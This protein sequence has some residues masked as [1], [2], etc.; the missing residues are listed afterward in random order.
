MLLPSL[1]YA[2]L[3]GFPANNSYT[4]EKI[5]FPV[6]QKQVSHKQNEEHDCRYQEL[7]IVFGVHHGV[8]LTLFHPAYVIIYLGEADACAACPDIPSTGDRG[9]FLKSLFI[10]P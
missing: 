2:F 7:F 8:D 10:E 5:V 1:S 4:P 3:F 9:N 6:S